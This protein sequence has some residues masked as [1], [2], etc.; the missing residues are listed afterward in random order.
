M[1]ISKQQLVQIGI[2]LIATVISCYI[3]FYNRFP[4]VYSD[5]GTYL[6]SGFLGDVPVDRPIFYGLFARH[7]S[8][9]S[10]LW[11]VIF[12]QGLITCY[13]I[14]L[15]FGMFFTGAKRNGLFLGTVTFLALTTGLSYNVSMLIPDIFVA[16]A[17][18]AFLNLLLN[19]RLALGHLITVSI[20]YVFSLTTHLSNLPVFL[21]LLVGL[22]IFW[23]IRKW[24]K[25]P[26]LIRTNRLILGISLF[27]TTLLLIPTVNYAFSGDFR[28]SKGSHVFMMNHLLEIQVLEDYLAAECPDAGYKFCEHQ[29]N[30]GLNFIWRMDSPLYKT[31]GW[32][33]NEAE[34]KTIIADIFS[35]PKYLIRIFQSAI[36]FSFKQYFTYDVDVIYPQLEGS[37][38]YGQISWR[39]H[40]SLTE[41]A[42]SLQNQG[43]LDIS[44][45]NKL[46]PFIILPSM[47]FLF[48]LIFNPAW[49]TKLS[50][51]LRWTVGLFLVFTVVSAIICS[52]LSTVE[53]RYQNRIVWILPLL[54]IVVLVKF[55][56][57]GLLARKASDPSSS[58]EQLDA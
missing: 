15:T 47:A 44:L 4:L 33:A 29:D 1:R 58:S 9:A 43:K 3:G 6:G 7:I 27:A 24:K 48:L 54:S 8:L 32:E 20:I 25:Q 12:V 17:I 46:Q 45:I 40:N 31:G 55:R 18:I 26:H 23:A 56:E 11:L 41:Y 53:P 5:T 52:N 57:L 22:A 35:K 51:E 16:T 21:L 39:F 30:L 28:T 34:Y 10:S 36:E 14:Y 13:L 42:G 2:V 50:L 19:P 49:F 37:S 38:P